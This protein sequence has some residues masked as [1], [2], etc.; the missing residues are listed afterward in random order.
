VCLW[1]RRTGQEIK[2]LAVGQEVDSFD[3]KFEAV[4]F[5]PVDKTGTSMYL[6]S[7]SDISAVPG[8]QQ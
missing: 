1:D 4:A 8:Y 2:K 3:R 6:V 7:L 5:S